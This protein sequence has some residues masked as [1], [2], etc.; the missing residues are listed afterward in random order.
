IT[1]ADINHEAL[2]ALAFQ[3]RKPFHNAIHVRAVSRFKSPLSS[4]EL[5]ARASRLCE[6]WLWPESHGQDARATISDAP[7]TSTSA[8]PASN[9]PAPPKSPASSKQST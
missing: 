7:T 4:V 2:F 5:V 1:R 9:P 8:P 6:P 3:P